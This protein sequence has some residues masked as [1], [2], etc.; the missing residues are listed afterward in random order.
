MI[1]FFWSL[2]IHS[3]QLFCRQNT[4]VSLVWSGPA[5]SNISFSFG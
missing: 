4:M 2:N 3:Y 5:R 1:R